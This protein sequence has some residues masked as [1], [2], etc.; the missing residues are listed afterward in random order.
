MQSSSVHA[1]WHDKFLSFIRFAITDIKSRSQGVCYEGYLQEQANPLAGMPCQRIQENIA[2]LHSFHMY[3][4]EKVRPKKCIPSTVCF[5][6]LVTCQHPSWDCGIS[7]FCRFTSQ[8]L[9]YLFLFPFSYV[10]YCMS[11]CPISSHTALTSSH[12]VL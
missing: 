4:V 7:M 2:Q 3:S 8:Q 1:R 5:V 12:T 11:C 9:V 6:R 10:I